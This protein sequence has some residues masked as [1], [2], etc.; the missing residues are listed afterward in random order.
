[1]S[2]FKALQDTVILYWKAGVL[3]RVHSSI[4]S[5]SNTPHSPQL[6]MKATR[7]LFFLLKTG[8]QAF[9]KKFCVVLIGYTCGLEKIF[10]LLFNF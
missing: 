8:L 10:L 4:D 5:I 9:G 1:M 6:Y 7:V 3:P 2:Q